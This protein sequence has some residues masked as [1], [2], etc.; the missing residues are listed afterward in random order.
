MFVAYL[1]SDAAA[2]RVAEDTMAAHLETSAALK[3]YERYPDA[4]DVD[5]AAIRDELRA[6]G[7]DGAAILHLA[8]VEQELSYSGGAYPGYYRSFGGYWGWASAPVDVRTDEIVHV[9]T[10]VYSLVEDKLLYTARSETFNPRSTAR[11][12]EEIA[13][14]IR[15]DLQEKGLLR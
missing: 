11:M 14:A 13:E 10:N 7:C 4:R 12:I 5:P 6:A 2:Q 9:V 3:C 8:R 1:G 15:A